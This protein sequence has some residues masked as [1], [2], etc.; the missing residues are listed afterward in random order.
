MKPLTPIKIVWIIQIFFILGIIGLAVGISFK[1][2]P[3]TED[4]LSYILQNELALFITY[5]IFVGIDIILFLI[6][7]FGSWE[8]I[9]YTQPISFAGLYLYFS[10]VLLLTSFFVPA[11]NNANNINS[12]R[13]FNTH[14]LIFFTDVLLL[15]LT[16]V[17]ATI[18]TVKMQVKHSSKQ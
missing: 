5:C 9:Q 15:F 12:T 10:A 18:E 3:E 6:V 16:I 2:P 8:V 11:V 1:V 4:P 7:G 17:A 14:P 13:F